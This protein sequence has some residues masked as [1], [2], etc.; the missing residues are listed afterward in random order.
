MTK[1]KLLFILSVLVVITTSGIFYVQKTSTVE[2]VILHTNDHH[3]Y[4]WAR[5]GKGG[6][7]KQLT[8]IKKIKSEN[9]NVLVLSAGDINTGYP[10]SDISQAEPS[11][12]GMNLLGFDA[13]AVGNHEFDKPS[14]VLRQ[15]E[16]WAEFP[17]LSANVYDSNSGKRLFKPYIVENIGGLN[18]GIL[19]LTTEETTYI[20]TETR[21]IEFVDVIKEAQKVMPELEKK[22]DLVIGLTHL[23]VIQ[24]RNHPTRG[25]S[26]QTLAAEFPQLI[27]IVGGHSHTLLNDPIIVGKTIIVQAKHYAEYLGELHLKINKKSKKLKTYTYKLH[28]LNETIPE[29]PEMIS[30]LEPYLQKASVLFDQKVG[31]STVELDGK[32]ENVRSQETNLGNLVTDVFREAT[33]A[34]VAIQNSG[35]IRASIPKGEVKF[36]D[37]QQSFPFNNTIVTLKLKGGEILELLNRSASLQR[38]AGGFVQVSGLVFE[39]DKDRVKNVKV[40]K[41]PLDYNRVYVVATN[42]FT[43]GGGDGY[44]MLKDQP[45]VDTG[46]TIA[47]AMK[48][49]IQSRKTISPTVERRIKIKN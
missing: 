13:M 4:C 23:G 48:K 7:A 8:L 14:P 26:N 12:K 39:I 29:D 44:T 22:S 35:G 30:F 28:E 11:F 49:Y 32:R 17:F 46:I 16:S 36:R 40:N 19:G 5:E 15:Q 3:G 1:R 20:A 38:P 47:A 43:A 25:T 2:L 33:G 9:K 41:Q 10:E 24:D 34:Q 31:E 21:G 45:R 42:D 6:F 37:I 27:A 18:V